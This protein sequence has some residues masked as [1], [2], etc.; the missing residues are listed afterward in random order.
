MPAR[1]PTATRCARQTISPHRCREA[2]NS[3]IGKRHRPFFSINRQNLKDQTIF[4]RGVGD[5][6][7][8]IETVAKCQ[9]NQ[10]LPVQYGKPQQH[11]LAIHRRH[12]RPDARLKYCPCSLHSTINVCCLT[13]G[14]HR[15]NSV[16][17]RV[18]A[19]KRL[20]RHRAYKFAI[21]LGPVS[22][23][24]RICRPIPISL[25]QFCYVE[26]AYHTGSLGRFVHSMAF[27]RRQIL[28]ASAAAVQEHECRQLAPGHSCVSNLAVITS[29]VGK[30]RMRGIHTHRRNLSNKDV[31]R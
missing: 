22:N 31:V 9:F 7:P 23:L 28:P 14:H 27:A 11:G 1:N 13:F 17:R 15:K 30:N 5:Q 24:Q 3:V 4:R 20:T 16:S 6:L 2:I 8:Y 25:P 21:N 19:A 18:D 12:R 29:A 10:I 26:W